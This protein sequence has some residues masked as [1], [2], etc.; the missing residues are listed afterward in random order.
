MSDDTKPTDAFSTWVNARVADGSWLRLSLSDAWDAGI[1]A[2]RARRDK[3]RGEK[4]GWD[5][6][7][8]TAHHAKLDPA[9]E[10]DEIEYA[11]RRALFEAGVSWA[12]S[13]DSE[14][15]ADLRAKVAELEAH[16]LAVAEAIGIAYTPD[17]GPCAPGPRDRVLE[18]I[19]NTVRK[20]NCALDSPAP[21][22]GEL[23]ERVAVAG[24]NASRVSSFD[25]A[26]LGHTEQESWRRL[27]RAVLAGDYKPPTKPTAGKGLDATM[28]LGQAV[29]RLAAPPL[30]PS[31]KAEEMAREA[32]PVPMYLTCPKCRRKARAVAASKG[33]K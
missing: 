10:D 4:P 9:D 11:R 23:V 19:R 12:D 15:L 8:Y 21:A 31:A 16:E 29:E 6:L 33:E 13:A 3:G 1:S 18:E 28:T 5:T 26:R 25:F 17:T 22:D 2:E 27:A 20:A 30:G 14:E 24:W 32:Q 7:H